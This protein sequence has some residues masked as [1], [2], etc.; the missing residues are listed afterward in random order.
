MVP[1]RCGARDSTRDRLPGV[2]DVDCKRKP[3]FGRVDARVQ[4]SRHPSCAATRGSCRR[5]RITKA[6]RNKATT[7]RRNAYVIDRTI[8][9]PGSDCEAEATG[10]ASARVGTK[11]WAAHSAAKRFVEEARRNYAALPQPH[12]RSSLGWSSMA[13]GG[14][15]CRTPRQGALAIRPA[16]PTREQSKTISG[17]CRSSPT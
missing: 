10:L 3:I 9:T 11:T 15:E 6:T 4:G 12:I 14:R 7:C 8:L 16:F 13:A 17:A 2:K 1:E 5:A